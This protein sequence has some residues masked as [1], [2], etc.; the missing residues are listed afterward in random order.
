MTEEQVVQLAP[1]AASLKAGKALAVENKWVTL[2]YNSR[3]LWGEVQGSGKEPYRTQVD[4]QQTAFKCSCPSRKFPCKHGLG[5]LLLFAKSAP[6]FKN[7]EDEPAWVSEWIGKRQTKAEKAAEPAAEVNPEQ[8]EKDRLKR[9]QQRYQKVDAGVGEL[10]QWLR[11]MV[12]TGT[13]SVPEKGPR[14]FEQ[15]AARMVDAQATGLANGVKAFNHIAYSGS[16]WQSEVLKQCSQLYLWTQAFKNL[17][18][19]QPP[20]QED[21]KNAIGWGRSAKDLGE[22]AESVTDDW[23]VLGRM[24]REEDRITVQQN[25]LYGYTSGRIALILNFSY[26]NAGVET[27]LVPGRIS[28]ATLQFYPSAFPFRA[29]VAEHRGYEN[30]Y[31]QANAFPDFSEAETFLNQIW[32]AQP[33][34]DEIPLWVDQL[35]LVKAEN[36]WFLRDNKSQV[37]SIDS[38]FD[39]MKILQLLAL[40]GGQSMRLAILYSEGSVYPLGFQL[41]ATY[42]L[43]AV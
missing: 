33:W 42:H 28:K 20:L 19:L 34:A 17:P 35:Q 32:Q 26:Q 8:K 36:D 31:P 13:L 5:L 6:G 23:L 9:Q 43:L 30:M 2:S 24:S 11:D 29:L 40:S 37:M 22:E 14:Y 16:N 3:V 7:S 38:A 10:S 27:P 1:D 15:T 21:V 39:E 18:Q 12:R 4:L 25:W 41:G